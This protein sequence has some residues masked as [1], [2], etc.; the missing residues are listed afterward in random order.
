MK[1]VIAGVAVRPSEVV[2]GVK[3]YEPIHPVEP[4]LGEVWYHP[5]LPELKEEQTWAEFEAMMMGAFGLTVLRRCMEDDP[6]VPWE[7]ELRLDL[8]EPVSPF[9]DDAAFLL[10]LSEDED[11]PFAIWG[12]PGECPSLS[13]KRRHHFTPPI[14]VE[15][16]P[17]SADRFGIEGPTPVEVIRM[18]G[19]QAAEQE[20]RVLLAE[21]EGMP[22]VPVVGKGVMDCCAHGVMNLDYCRECDS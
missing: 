3:G 10:V 7:D 9:V 2:C 16:T 8:W 20:L 21:D 6:G 1:K 15:T 11:G 19:P 4:T 14:I 13:Q 18:E 12:L 5:A 22:W 17:I